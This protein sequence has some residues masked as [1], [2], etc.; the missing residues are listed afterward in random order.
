MAAIPLNRPESKNQIDFVS[1]TEHRALFYQL[2]WPPDEKT[3][4]PTGE[5]CNFCAGGDVRKIIGLQTAS[6]APV[7]QMCTS[8]Q[9]EQS[10][11]SLHVQV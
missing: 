7:P 9:Y 5:G 6:K 2:H 8:M 11:E 3:E 1:Y 10:A 4:V